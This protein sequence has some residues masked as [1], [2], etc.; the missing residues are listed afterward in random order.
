MADWSQPIQTTGYLTL[1]DNLKSR[2]VDAITLCLVDPTTIPTGAFK[3]DRVGNKFQEYDGAAFQDKVLSLAGGGTGA[4]TAGGARTTLGLGTMAV[5]NANN[6]AITGGS[7]AE[8][9]ISD[10]G[11]LARIAANETISGSWTFAENVSLLKNGNG[12][13]NLKIRNSDVGAFAVVEIYL[14]NSISLSRSYLTQTGS[15]FTTSGI[16][17][18]DSLVIESA[19]VGGLS[20]SSANAAG[21]IH[22]WTN[23]THRVRIQAD[24]KIG[25]GYN[26]VTSSPSNNL[27][28]IST[29][30]GVGA[31]GMRITKGVGNNDYIIIN[32]DSSG[33]AL[34]QAGNNSSNIDLRLNP[35]GGS[36][37]LSS[38][39]YKADSTAFS[40]DGADNTYDLGTSAR[41]FRNSYVR[42]H[43]ASA[44]VISTTGGYAFIGDTDT[45]LQSS[46]ADTL[47]LMCGNSQ[48]IALSTSVIT[49][50]KRTTVNGNHLPVTDNA[51]SSGEI[52]N[53]WTAV[54]AVNGT[55]QT[56]DARMKKN[57]KT[58]EHGL[59]FLLKMK[60]VEY[61]WKHDNSKHYGVIAQDLLELD[62]DFAAVNQEAPANLAVNYSEI[63][64]V[65]IKSIQELTALYYT[66]HED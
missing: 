53:R 49:L 13:L 48:I 34:L 14:G 35:S 36:V 32:S 7:I 15:G 63:I 26:V 17:I 60:P 8:A 54:Y 55:I 42:T 21:S 41:R 12:S 38:N 61:K 52:A 51:S 9:A 3:Y 37:L 29:A 6:V 20:I 22:L 58:I 25:I 45:G 40:P 50:D 27:D 59:E 5:Q 11:I 47:Q 31:G 64:P 19:G 18:Q 57:I 56:S 10:D 24:G 46:G 28:L 33:Y 62:P 2:D 23:G 44:G 66:G 43:L 30:N 65:L 16:Y 4:T 39:I 1:L